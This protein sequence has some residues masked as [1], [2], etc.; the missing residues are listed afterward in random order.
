MPSDAKTFRKMW[1][2]NDENV[3]LRKALEEA[4]IAIESALTTHQ[5]MNEDPPWRGNSVMEGCV[6]GAWF[7]TPTKLRKAIDL[8][9]EVLTKPKS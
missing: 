6:R 5:V 3:R 2:L 4:R 8:I 9:E 1:A 7:D